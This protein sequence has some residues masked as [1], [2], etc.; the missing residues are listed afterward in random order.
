MW[1]LMAEFA[2]NNSYSQTIQTT[3]FRALYGY[4]P[5][6][7]AEVRDEPSEG[8]VPAAKERVLRLIKER[9]SLINHWRRAS[10]SQAKYY[11]KSY[12]P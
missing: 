12:M 8:E 4:D 6:L 1:L 11:N 3:P 7:Q 9:D 2:A 5:Q 10:E